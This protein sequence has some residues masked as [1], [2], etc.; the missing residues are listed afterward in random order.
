ML[1]LSHLKL[2]EVGEWSEIKVSILNEY[3]KAYTKILQKQNYMDFIYIDAFSGAGIN[4]SKDTGQIL[5]G[6][7][8]TALSIK[9]EFSEYHFIDLDHNKTQILKNLAGRRSN[10]YF[11]TEDC[12]TVLL[13]KL[14]P[15]IEYGEYKRALCILDP[16]GLHLD[17]K[18]IEAAG[19]KR[20]IEIFLN[21]PI[22]DMNRS[23]FW[24]VPELVPMEYIG[25]MN[26]FWGDDSWKNIAYEED[27]NLFNQDWKIKK[28]HKTVAKAFQRR[29]KEVAHFKYVPAPV[30]MRNTKNSPL[31]YLFFASQNKTASKIASYLF[32]KYGVE[33]GEW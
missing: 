26:C 31:Y 27:L 15:R 9:P 11:Y 16:Y 24:K 3:E 6:S 2:D 25:R 22:M 13:E 4:I 8:M 18:V 28:D 12:N 30:L 7:P 5:Y 10:V 21:F 29:I 14:I 32:S 20:T 1:D 19:K 23:V 17:W 33:N